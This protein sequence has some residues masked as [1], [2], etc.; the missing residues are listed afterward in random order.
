MLEL[1]EGT[2]TINRAIYRCLKRFQGI[3][4]FGLYYT[5]SIL[6]LSTCQP[7]G[8]CGFLDLFLYTVFMLHSESNPY[9][10]GNNYLI[11]PFCSI[12]LACTIKNLLGL[13]SL[14]T[15]QPLL[16]VGGLNPTQ[17]QHTTQKQPFYEWF[18]LWIS[19]MG[20]TRHRNKGGKLF[21]EDWERLL[22]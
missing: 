7:V 15:P 16:E 12:D 21:F 3:T 11:C 1:S 20:K 17:D 14:I 18:I 22:K 2:W 13:P 10:T 6:S 9:L 4:L 5:Y 8:Q 19:K